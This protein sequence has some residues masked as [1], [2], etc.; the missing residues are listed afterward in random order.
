[1][2]LNMGKGVKRGGGGGGRRGCHLQEK[3]MKISFCLILLTGKQLLTL[4]R[5]A[6]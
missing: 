6:M 3:F 1:M 2:I 4:E 5:T